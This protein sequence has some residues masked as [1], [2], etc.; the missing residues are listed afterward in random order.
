M[1]HCFMRTPGRVQ[2]STVC[3][4]PTLHANLVDG[5]MSEAAR[6]SFI[7]TRRPRMMT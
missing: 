7:S 4:N 6:P 1:L 3:L 2:H 5:R